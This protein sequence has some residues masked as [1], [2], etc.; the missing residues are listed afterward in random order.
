[1]NCGIRE[2]ST[3]N[4]TN[5]VVVITDPRRNMI[6]GIRSSRHL[7]KRMLFS[8]F[9][10]STRDAY[11]TDRAIAALHMYAHIVAQK[12]GASFEETLDYIVDCEPESAETF[13]DD[14]AEIGLHCRHSN[15]DIS[16]LDSRCS[17]QATKWIRAL[18]FNTDL[19]FLQSAAPLNN[20]TGNVDFSIPLPISCSNYIMG[21]SFAI[22][23]H[24][25]NNNDGNWSSPHKLR[26]CAILGAGG[27][28]LPMVLTFLFPSAR[29]DAVEISQS[30]R[31]AALDYFGVAPLVDA[32]R[33]KLHEGCAL[34]WIEDEA[35]G[36]KGQDDCF[37][38]IF[39]DIYQT[40]EQ[41]DDS[42]THSR[43]T[44][45]S[46]VHSL[47]SDSTESEPLAPG[48]ILAPS[49]Q[50]L[51]GDTLSLL[52]DRLA[53]RGVLAINVLANECGH[54]YAF[55]Y[56]SKALADKAAGGGD[57]Y[58]VGMMKLRL[59]DKAESEGHV[60]I[61]STR[62]ND[63]SG[64]DAEVEGSAAEMEGSAATASAD[65]RY[66]STIYVVKNPAVW[67]DNISKTPS[68]T[69]GKRISEAVREYIHHFES[70]ADVKHP[71]DRDDTESID[72]LHSWM[73]TYLG[74][75]IRLGNDRYSSLS[76]TDID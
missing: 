11:M 30:V 53:V 39:V 36:A 41:S 3:T 63:A 13:V 54:M 34:Q 16:I 62:E 9:H 29:V 55:N 40:K 72:H 4:S 74:Y 70:E 14:L 1:M 31:Q 12:S 45:P 43:R 32:G 21:M 68:E 46:V 49:Q 10:A 60:M 69:C 8:T 5:F 65:K 18:H 64:S 28:V 25:I 27:C 50:V 38:L 6:L 51:R 75:N 52:A 71:F 76:L 37:D 67:Y 48:D 2:Y 47:C 61:S 22:L 7:L 20:N 58:H 26:R 15:A 59:I 19:D 73:N 44:Q 56:V 57:H 17:L 42:A 33:I 66:N 35:I 23:F 24:S